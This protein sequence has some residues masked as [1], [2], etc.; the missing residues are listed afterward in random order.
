MRLYGIKR[1]Q[2]KGIQDICRQIKANVDIYIYAKRIGDKTNQN[3][4]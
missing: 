2:N 4:T 3:K 1:I